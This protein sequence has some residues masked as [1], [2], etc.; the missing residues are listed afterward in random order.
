[1]AI[2]STKEG[3]FIEQLL[4]DAAVM[5][6]VE[7]ILGK[8]VKRSKKET[9]KVLMAELNHCKSVHFI[10]DRL[11][12]LQAI[13]TDPALQGVNLYLAGWGYNTAQDREIAR[14]DDRIHLLETIDYD[15]IEVL[16]SSKFSHAISARATD[17]RN[18]QHSQ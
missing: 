5:L 18:S 6:P 9:L 8:E 15:K 11:A 10:E 16:A 14:Q 4:A 3:R 7:R 17:S 2:V 1:V 13:L 12:A